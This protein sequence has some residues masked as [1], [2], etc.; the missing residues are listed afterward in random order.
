MHGPWPAAAL[1]WY[2]DELM[3]LPA[4]RIRPID[5][6]R[7]WFS[8]CHPGGNDPT[9]SNALCRGQLLSTGTTFRRP[10]LDVW[11]EI[12]RSYDGPLF[13]Q[14]PVVS[15]C[16]QIMRPSHNAGPLHPHAGLNPHSEISM[17]R[18]TSGYS[19]NTTTAVF[20]INPGQPIIVANSIDVVH[21][22][23]LAE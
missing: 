5:V 7:G 9:E 11:T 23:V 20:I 2:A 10:M 8:C 13:H 3:Q 12:P 21:R 16:M 19:N 4:K 22:R 6:A 18:S 14:S 17:D 1:L 15:H